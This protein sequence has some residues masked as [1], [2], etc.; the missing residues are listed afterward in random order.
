[1][2]KKS[3]SDVNITIEVHLDYVHR[4]MT[5]GLTLFMA[6]VGKTHRPFIDQHNPK[7]MNFNP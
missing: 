2:S 5:C 7:L 4:E 3:K 6:N 1:M